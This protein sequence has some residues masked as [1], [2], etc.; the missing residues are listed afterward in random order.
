MRLERTV[1]RMAVYETREKLKELKGIM[2]RI[3]DYL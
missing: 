2:E 1:I 3:G